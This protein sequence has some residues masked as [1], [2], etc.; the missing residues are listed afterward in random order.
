MSRRRD[1]V[2]SFLEQHLARGQEGDVEAYA[3]GW[4]DALA[5]LYEILRKAEKGRRLPRPPR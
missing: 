2:Q 3:E 5:D 4:R 1:V